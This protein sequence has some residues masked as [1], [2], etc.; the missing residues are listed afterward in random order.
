MKVIFEV[1]SEADIKKIDESSRYILK[2][3]GVKIPDA[4]T[5]NFLIDNGAN[6]GKGSDDVI[7][8]PEEVIEKSLAKKELA[9]TLYGIDKSK[10]ACFTNGNCL[11]Q[12]SSGQYAFID[13]VIL[14][15]KEPDYNSFISGLRLGDMLENIDINGGFLVPQY[16]ELEK[17]SSYIAYNLL[18]NTSKPFHFWIDNGVSAKKIIQA[19]ESVRGSKKDLVD[20]PLSYAFIEPI[21]PLKYSQESLE[22]LW[23][24]AEYG[25]PI[26][27]GPM[28]MTYATAPGTLAGTIVLENAEI[29]SGIIIARLINRNVPICYWG[30]P[31]IMDLRKGNIS[32]GSP[33]QIIMGVAMTQMA[34]F[35]GFPVGTNTGLSDAIAADSQSGIERGV[36]A[37]LAF[38]SGSSICGHMGICG[39]D[40]GASFEQ[41]VIDNEMIS[42]IKRIFEPIDISNST[43]LLEEIKETGI[44]GNFLNSETTLKNF[45]K[46]TWMPSVFSR[47][48]W[49]IFK[50][51]M[52]TIEEKAKNK[53]MELLKE[54]ESKKEKSFIGEDLDKELV[55][56][57]GI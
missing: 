4:R 51:E 14:K 34:K 42:Y 31:H 27:I 24:F 33:E 32:F 13:Q 11:F 49:D 8:F 45:R 15:R 3:I 47:Y 46:E 37:V 40:Q 17:R 29:L 16:V 35:Y 41:L 25:I 20:Y 57:L 23:E 50:E 6:L 1:L 10:K 19:F 30:I 28:A 55:K 52:P 44:G 53:V 54:Y 48:N 21:S 12:S 5:R 22:I 36:S 2:D 7:R 39:A 26:G 43:I 18:K 9:Y 38:A 56:I